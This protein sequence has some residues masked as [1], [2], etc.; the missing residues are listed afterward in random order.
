M[1]ARRKFEKSLRGSVI[2]GLAV[3]GFNIPISSAANA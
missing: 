2:A 1:L 3:G